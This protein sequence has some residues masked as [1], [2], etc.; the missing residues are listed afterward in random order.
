[1]L[2]TL[3]AKTLQ[4]YFQEK[5]DITLVSKQYKIISA[6]LAKELVVELCF[7]FYFDEE[8]L[9]SYLTNYLL[10]HASGREIVIKCSY[11]VIPTKIDNFVKGLPNIKNIIAISSGKGGVGK[12]TVAVNVAYALSQLG[13]KVGLLDADIHGPSIPTMLGVVKQTKNSMAAV[14]S[15]G[16][17]T[18]SI[19]YFMTNDDPVVWRG[20][21]VSRALEQLLFDVDWGDL[22]YLFIDMPPGTGDIA[23]TLTK[24]LPVTAAVVVTTPQEVACIDATKAAAMFNKT[25]VAMLGVV[26]N[27]S[28]HQCQQCGHLESI[29]G[30]GG[31]QNL[32]DKFSIPLLG[33]VPLNRAIEHAADNGDPDM[34]SHVKVKNIYTTIA[35]KLGLEI[36]LRPKDYMRKF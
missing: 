4:H 22:D 16:L 30:A 8:S 34:L 28:A 12:S 32:A 1:M 29:F 13:A 7:A 24:K 36:S 25:N 17:A 2:K 6:T 14:M 5:L 3:I 15:H 35:I 26:E 19:S 27:M 31:G 23:L 10:E 21:M 11:N 9:C 18:A 33:Q 20:P